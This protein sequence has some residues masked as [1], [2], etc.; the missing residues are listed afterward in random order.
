MSIMDN[1]DTLLDFG[2]DSSTVHATQLS[3][4]SAAAHN[5]ASSAFDPFS[6]G[7][8]DPFASTAGDFEV[9]FCIV[10]FINCLLD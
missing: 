10:L 5:F 4:T 8:D 1:T 2:D 7:P 3:P 9:W 6:S